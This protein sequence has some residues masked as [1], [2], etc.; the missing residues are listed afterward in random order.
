LQVQNC[1]SRIASPE[2]QVQNCSSRIAIWESTIAAEH[3][4]QGV[5][6]FSVIWEV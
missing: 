4:A 3:C 2:L 6:A 5:Y 1:K